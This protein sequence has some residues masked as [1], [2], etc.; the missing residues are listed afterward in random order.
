MMYLTRSAPR[1]F[2]AVV[3]ALKV[4][5]DS[6][7]MLRCCMACAIHLAQSSELACNCGHRLSLP[8]LALPGDPETIVTV[9]MVV[10]QYSEGSNIR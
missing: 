7:V 2:L 1:I 8:Q 3:M 9:V 6:S 10:T 5:C 4:S